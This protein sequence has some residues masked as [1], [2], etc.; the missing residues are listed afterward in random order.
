VGLGYFAGALVPVLPVLFGAKGMLPTVVTAGTT[1]VAVSAIVAFIS[2][3]DVRRRI[4][5]NALVTGIAVLVTY[6]IGL[7]AKQVWGVAL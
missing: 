2:G 6:T 7:L 3:M 5:Q 1:I 4:A